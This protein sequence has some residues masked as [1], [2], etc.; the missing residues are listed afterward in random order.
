MTAAKPILYGVS[1][2]PF[3]RKVRA[4]LAIKQIEYDL[5]PVMPG[6]MDASFRAKS[7]LS[8]VPVW[9]EEGW[10]LPDSSVICSYLERR[11]PTPSVYPESPR[12]FATALFWEEYADT[13]LVE[14]G[15][16]IFFQRIVHGRIFGRP[17]DE[18][19]VRRHLEE[20]L[21][22]VLDQLE[23]LFVRRDEPDAARP[24][25]AEISVWSVFVNLAHAGE[26]VD[27][28]RW[29]GLAAFLEKMNARPLLRS[30][31]EEERA[32]LAAH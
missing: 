10:T 21:P 8:K 29:P 30:L 1:L 25:I 32:A 18:G 12:A 15:G 20:V 22:P 17:V 26:A 4:V 2:S 24:G 3:V 31:V 11:W 28:T 19:L 27:A 6:A 9:E 13:R 16:P 23:S 14:S 7:P 5:S